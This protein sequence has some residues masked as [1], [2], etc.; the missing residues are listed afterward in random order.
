MNPAN[1]ISQ[2]LITP[3]AHLFFP[4]I[5]RGCAIELNN[6]KESLCLSCA[7][8]LPYTH[9]ALLHNNPVEKTFWGR[10]EVQAAMSLLYFTPGSITQ[11]LMH[12]LKYNGCKQLGNYLGQLMGYE[13]MGASR[14]S[15]IDAIIPLPLFAAK[16]KSRGYNQA[17]VI[18]EGITHIT[19]IPVYTDWMARTHF[20]ATQTKKTREERWQ[21]VDGLF[22]VTNPIALENKTILLVDDV[23]TTGA[24]LEACGAAIKKISG[25]SVFVAT[26]AFAMQ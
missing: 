1:Y 18:A 9:F 10:L 15:A 17:T 20:T 8:D 26:L 3:M 25:T 4:Q 5:C 2:Q 24:T 11:R 14:F 19:Q 21:N 16:E 13:I 22:T 23:L 6:N 7:A 12:Q